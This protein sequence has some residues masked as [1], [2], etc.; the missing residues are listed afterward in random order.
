MQKNIHLK[1]QLEICFRKTLHATLARTVWSQF[2]KYM[3]FCTYNP[4]QTIWHLIITIIMINAN[5]LGMALL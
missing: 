1:D 5:T 4:K 2:Y 3:N